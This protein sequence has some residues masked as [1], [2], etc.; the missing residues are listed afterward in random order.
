[1]GLAYRA[2]DRTDFRK[3]NMQ[4]LPAPLLSGLSIAFDLDGTLVETA[5]DLV[6]VTSEVI[7]T[8]GHGPVDYKLARAEVGYGSRKML[9]TAL[10][11]VGDQVNEADMD[12][13]Q[14]LFLK[15]YADSIDHLSHPFP[16]VEK[17]LITL[18]A[19]GAELSV[20]TNKPGWL[21]RPLMEKLNLSRHFVRIIGGDDVPRKKPDADHIFAAVGHRNSYRIIMVGDS[22]PD[23]RS[24]QNAK[25]FPILM[26][27]GYTPLPQIRLR[28]GSRLSRFR[29]IVP[30]LQARI[31]AGRI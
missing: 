23:M 2:T 9:Y 24:A 21:A 1:M 12:D 26:T 11:A 10:N 6:R 17:T 5:P 30:A 3:L 15:F 29:D 18:N 28:A 14:A 7:A 8:R 4:K 22:W 31:S 25:A 19:L 16:G 20:C 27:Y 13:L